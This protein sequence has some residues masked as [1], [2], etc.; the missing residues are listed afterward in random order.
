MVKR[1]F[2]KPINEGGILLNI[3]MEK[4]ETWR[5]ANPSTMTSFPAGRQNPINMSAKAI[6][7]TIV[8]RVLTGC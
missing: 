1:R 2:L 3:S 7:P 8:L 4:Y 5:T 6:S